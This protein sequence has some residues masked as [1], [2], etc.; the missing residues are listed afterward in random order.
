MLQLFT[1]TQHRRPR[2]LEV[3][4]L[5]VQGT[6][7]IPLRMYH[8]SSRLM[9]VRRAH[10]QRLE[11]GRL[12]E[13]RSS[14]FQ[15]TRSLV[16]QLR[17]RRRSSR[18]TLQL[19]ASNPAIPAAR[20]IHLQLQAALQRSLRAPPCRQ[21]GSWRRPSAAFTPTRRWGWTRPAHSRLCHFCRH[22]ADLAARTTQQLNRRPRR[23]YEGMHCRAG[24]PHRLTA[25]WTNGIHWLACRR[26]CP[27][28]AQAQRA[29]VH[30]AT[31]TPT[32]STTTTQQAAGCTA[33]CGR[34]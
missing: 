8:C 28:A 7:W 2:A 23:R 3:L 15:G 34:R 18:R 1:P 20:R 11:T 27:V 5:L 19:L 21:C 14:R 17:H 30:W 26:Q 22:R 31:P 24:G 12:G 6:A 9:C 25:T 10:C 16:S 4:L 13:W 29:G 33:L 32:A